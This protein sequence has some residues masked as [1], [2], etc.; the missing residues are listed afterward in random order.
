MYARA[1]ARPSERRQRRL[2]R[3]RLDVADAKGMITK[4]SSKELGA[5]TRI[6]DMSRERR[7]EAVE[8]ATR[9]FRVAVRVTPSLY[10]SR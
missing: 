4:L 10:R 5:L 9:G 7:R 3:W 8:Q 2:P 1:S 6:P